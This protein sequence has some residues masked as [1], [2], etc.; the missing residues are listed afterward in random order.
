MLVVFNL[1]WANLHPREA[2][3][4]DSLLAKTKNTNPAAK[5]APGLYQRPKSVHPSREEDRS[6]V[7]S[8]A[9]PQVF[10]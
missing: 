10:K 8:N 6:Q 3:P 1:P 4:S 2:S 7:P 5:T 9:T